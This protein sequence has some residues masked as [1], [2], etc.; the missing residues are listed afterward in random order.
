MAAIARKEAAANKERSLEEQ[1]KFQK[2]L[3]NITNLIHSAKDTNDI[4]LN[5]QGRSWV[6]SMPTGLPF[7]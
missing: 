1:L 2:R 6:F 4:L 3:N 7:M 5:L